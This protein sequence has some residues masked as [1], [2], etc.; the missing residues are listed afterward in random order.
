M[1]S[2]GDLGPDNQWFRVTKKGGKGA[3]L[4]A[5]GLVP[6]AYLLDDDRLKAKA[7]EWVEA[8]LA[9]QDESGW[10]GP[11]QGVLGDRKYP[12]YD[13]WP[14]FIVSKVLTQYHDHR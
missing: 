1:I 4:Y 9:G 3:L 7:Q 6:L 10:I 12:E 8:F 5:D 2:W 14:V 13:P 11:V